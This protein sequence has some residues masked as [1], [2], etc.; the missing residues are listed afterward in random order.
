MLQSMGSQRVRH[1][2]TTEL[3]ELPELTD[4]Q[5][6]I[7]GDL[8]KAYT[9]V[10]QPSFFLNQRFF[11][12]FDVDH[13]LSLYFITILLLFYVLV[14]WPQGMWNLSSPTRDQTHIACFGRRSLSHWTTR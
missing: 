8:T 4:L 6:S 7:R 1:N 13:F 5:L 9:S 3:T 14:F 2:R 12:F 11:F 10:T